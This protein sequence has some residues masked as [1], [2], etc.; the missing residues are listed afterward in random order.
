M[1]EPPAEGNFHGEYRRA[2]KS[3]G[4]YSSHMGYANNEDK[5]S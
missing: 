4:N 2:Q 1:D 5:K 3:V